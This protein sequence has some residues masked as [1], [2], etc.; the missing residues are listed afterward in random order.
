MENIKK[1]RLKLKEIVIIVLLIVFT[2]SIG[3]FIESRISSNKGNSDVISSGSLY[4]NN[5]VL[6]NFYQN[7]NYVESDSTT[8]KSTS[9]GEGEILGVSSGNG[10]GSPLSL[11]PAL[12]VSKRVKMLCAKNSGGEDLSDDAIAMTYQ[13]KGLRGPVKIS[14]NCE[15]Q[16]SKITYPVLSEGRAGSGSEAFVPVKNCNDSGGCDVY[17]KYPSLSN[18]KTIQKNNTVFTPV[19]EENKED[20]G[21]VY[22]DN[23]DDAFSFEVSTTISGTEKTE[24]E[25]SGSGD[26]SVSIIPSNTGC[27][28]D[29]FNSCKQS[30]PRAANTQST[31]MAKMQIPPVSEDIVDLRNYA[32][33]CNPMNINNLKIFK[34]PCES[35]KVAYNALTIN[36][37]NAV[38]S[39]VKEIDNC[40]LGKD[41]GADFVVGIEVSAITGSNSS[42]AKQTGSDGMGQTG[43]DLFADINTASKLPP[44]EVN[45]LMQDD[46]SLENAVI[47]DATL[48]DVYI[49]T[50]CEIVACGR[51]IETNCFYNASF[52]TANYY[53]SVNSMAPTS[54]EGISKLTLEEYLTAICK[55]NNCTEI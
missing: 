53:R 36:S 34:F 39:A 25:T 10:C 22:E 55:A 6:D 37:L 50:D 14:S 48:K 12:D 31:D 4:T 52:L 30:N 3:V 1:N 49:V 19:Y 26:T 46:I 9:S 44:T 11:E 28:S 5:L 29:Q 17:A 40:I 16:V 42:V 7:P 32:S 27:T 21:Y 2:V 41:C 45:M 33:E 54:N 8:Q 15:I 18:E 47:Q 13:Q 20:E 23:D 51:K 38:I 43:I 35:T 24:V